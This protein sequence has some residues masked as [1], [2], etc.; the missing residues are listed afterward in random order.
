MKYELPCEVV[1]DLLPLHIDALTSENVAESVEAHMLTCSD[2][3]REY[4][5]M[6]NTNDI[7]IQAKA[8]KS[9]MKKAKR[10]FSKKMTLIG[11]LVAIIASVASVATFTGV[12]GIYKYGD[13]VQ[14]E[15][16]NAIVTEI[17]FD[18]V[19]FNN[20]HSVFTY[21]GKKYEIS[22][23]EYAK[24]KK[25]GIIQKI[26]LNTIYTSDC[27]A[28]SGYDVDGEYICFVSVHSDGEVAKPSKESRN[29]WN[30]MQIAKP[31][32]KI[33]YI[34]SKDGIL[35]K[36]P[37]EYKIICEKEKSLA[38]SEIVENL[39]KTKAEESEMSEPKT[40]WE[41]D[42]YG[43]GKAKFKIEYWKSYDHDMDKMSYPLYIKG[44]AEGISFCGAFVDFERFVNNKLMYDDDE[45]GNC[46][47][48]YY[49]E[50][51]KTEC[52]YCSIVPSDCA[53][54]EIEGQK[55]DAK[56][57]T[58]NIEGVDYPV[59]YICGVVDNVSGSMEDW[60]RV[61]L[62]DNSGKAHTY[63]RY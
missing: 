27:F 60:G 30:W 14:S 61:T 51:T 24:A 21:D 40:I 1:R 26:H 33:V 44:K 23:E 34:N 41:S 20:D 43:E 25:N 19:E 16:I 8:D 59:T 38:V 63:D 46:D 6:K 13:V 4:D 58:I 47:A 17:D 53:Y 50:A 52:Y 7:Q 55:L 42:E 48:C 5:G 31:I 29:G 35:S 18:S 28:Q 32:D 37:D 57:T 45:Y 15:D 62:F 56:K 49:V 39:I 12:A 9:L 54:A 3:R 11:L 2:C 36:N 22:E 10:R